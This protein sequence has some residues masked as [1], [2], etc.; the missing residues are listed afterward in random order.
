MTLPPSDA[1]SSGLRLSDDPEQFAKFVERLRLLCRNRI[2]QGHEDITIGK[3]VI[4]EDLSTGL[5]A[6]DV[7]GPPL[8][9]A[10]GRSDV[11][12]RCFAMI[13]RDGELSIRTRQHHLLDELERQMILDE[14]ANI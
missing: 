4:G 3:F 8:N 13:S 2:A 14:L 9:R 7:V 11:M 1:K 10:W 12:R 6:I 5:I